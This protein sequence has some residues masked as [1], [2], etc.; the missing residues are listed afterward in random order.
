M[1]EQH[2]PVRGTRWHPGSAWR[3][4][5][6]MLSCGEPW[7]VDAR[8][9]AFGSGGHRV[10]R[11]HHPRSVED[12]G[13]HRESCRVRRTAPGEHQGRAG[14]QDRAAH[15]CPGADHRDQYLRVGSAHVRGPDRLRDRAGL[16]HENLGEVIEVGDGVDQ[17]KVGD[18]VVLPFNV[19]CGHCKNCERGLTELLPD[20]QAGQGVGRGRLRL[21]RHG[22]VGRAARRSFCAC[23]WATSTACD[24]RR[25]PTRSRTTT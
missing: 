7:V 23:P 12:S 3:I 15:R 1:P 5:Q 25:T 2:A 4:G 9:I 10:T 13:G 6:K 8:V 17:V 19:A 20:R 14:R 16:G 18:R 24:C 21:R 22:A 11:V